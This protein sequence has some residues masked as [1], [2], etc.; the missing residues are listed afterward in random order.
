[1]TDTTAPAV[2]YAQLTRTEIAA[3]APEAALVIPVGAT[4]QHG[5]DLPIATDHVI[6]EALVADAVRTG[7]FS[8]RVLVAPT[9]P[10]G[11]SE[12]HLAFAAASLTPT[13]FLAVFVDLIRSA[14]I[15]GFKHVMIVNGHGGNAELIRLAVTQASNEFE[16]VFAALSYWEAVTEV[17]GGK[18]GVSPGHAGKYEASLLMRVRP[19]LLPADT[20]FTAGEPNGQMQS[21]IGIG[22]RALVLRSHDWETTGGWTDDPDGSTP[23][24]GEAYRAAIV[25]GL[26]ERIAAFCDIPVS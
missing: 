7:T 6:C 14:V 3:I 11:H 5:P 12:H 21:G 24:D 20:V 15:S 10:Y 19:D 17:P 2:F 1:M 23:E 25:A 26:Q 22:G 18:F 8:R 16:G 9:M 13:T 4:E